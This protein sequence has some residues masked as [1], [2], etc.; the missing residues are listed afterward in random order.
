MQAYF[1]R[2]GTGYASEFVQIGKTMEKTC[3]Y[4]QETPLSTASKYFL[5]QGQLF[6]H[7][8]NA[9]NAKTYIVRLFISLW[10]D[11]RFSLNNYKS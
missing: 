2:V 8:Q 3:E 7:L 10:I 9:R 5:F 11:L 4:D 1:L 6:A